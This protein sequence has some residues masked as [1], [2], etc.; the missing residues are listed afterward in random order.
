MFDLTL[1]NRLVMAALTRF[2]A[3]FDSSIPNDLHVQY[4]S[5]RAAD[6][7]F[8]LTECVPCSEET[9]DHI[10]RCGIYSEEHVEGWKKVCDSVHDKNGRIFLQIWHG[11]RAIVK[12][13]IIAPSAIINRHQFRSHS[14]L[15]DFPEPLEMT[16]EDIERVIL[17]FRKSAELAKKAG[18]DGIQLHGANGYLI[19]NFLRDCSNKRNDDYGGSIENRVRFPLRVI[20]ELT[21]VFGSE[22]VGIKLSPIG[23]LNDM[24]DSDPISLYKHL[25]QELDRRNIAFVELMRGPEFRPVKN[26][27][28][29]GEL[30]QIEDVY[31][32]FRSYYKGI[33]I[34]NNSFDK[35]SAN[36]VIND[37]LADMVS[38]GRLYIS[39]P[40]LSKRF[41]YNWELN[42][43]DEKTFYTRGEI[44]YID[45]KSYN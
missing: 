18:F 25:L 20:D 41:A 31:K 44:G 23:R 28:G 37:G 24:F 42:K 1:K 26:L 13:G 5:E 35:N 19:D 38:F 36:Q 3:D 2:R 27:Y 45:Y 11:G 43:P 8:I 22:R 16:E 15:I 21:K 33:L 34:A 14:G 12:K 29:V 40:D 7:G 17:D 9:D 30:S 10:G 4:Y 32:T 39:N 6:A